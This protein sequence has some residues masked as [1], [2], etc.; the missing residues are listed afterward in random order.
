MNNCSS[1]KLC[2]PLEEYIIYQNAYIN[3]LG[4][5]QSQ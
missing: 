3:S 2:G 4:Q 1:G 5:N